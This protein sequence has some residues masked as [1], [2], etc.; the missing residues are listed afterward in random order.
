M[1]LFSLKEI[2]LMFN[3]LCCPEDEIT[4]DYV[5]GTY[6]LTVDNTHTHSSLTVRVAFLMLSLRRRRGW[7]LDC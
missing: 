2:Q 7:Y 4:F 6:S 3:H 1:D 5:V